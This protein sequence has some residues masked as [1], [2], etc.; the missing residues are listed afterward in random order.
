MLRRYAWPSQCPSFLLSSTCS[1]MQLVDGLLHLHSLQIM[2]GDIKPDN[3]MLSE[4]AN[5]NGTGGHLRLIDFGSAKPSAGVDEMHDEE[6]FTGDTMALHSRAR[7]NSP[8]CHGSTHEILPPPPGTPAYCAPELLHGS[9]PS[10]SV[11]LWAAGCVVFFMLTAKPPFGAKLN[12]N[13]YN[14]FQVPQ[15]ENLEKCP[16]RWHEQGA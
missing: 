5:G 9:P 3:I 16:D 7:P 4:P 10:A 11:D 2:H 6:A 12:T 1:L 15:G 13:D 8:V 14:T